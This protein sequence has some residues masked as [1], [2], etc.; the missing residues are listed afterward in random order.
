MM[1]AFA[2]DHAKMEVCIHVHGNIDEH[3]DG[4]TREPQLRGCVMNE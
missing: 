2:P 1:D 3:I 4:A